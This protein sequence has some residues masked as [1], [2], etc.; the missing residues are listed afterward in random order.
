MIDMDT[1]H[2]VDKILDKIGQKDLLNILVNDLSY[3]ELNS[4]L[5]E[6]YRR[7]TD[8]ISPT[9]LLNSYN[10][11]RFVH[12]TNANLKGLLELE[13]D[14]YKIAELFSFIPIDLSPVEPLGACSVIAPVNQN[15]VLSALR[16]TE[17]VADATNSM[18]LHI[19]NLKKNMN[20][21]SDKFKEKMRYCN[22]HHHIRTQKF[23]EPGFRPHFRVFSMITSGKDLGSYTFE[24]N[25]ILEHIM[26]YKEIFKQLFDI[27]DL[28]LR[29]INSGGYASEGLC[30][31]LNNHIEENISDLKVYV[32]KSKLD[33]INQYY[34]GIQ[35]KLSTIINDNEYEIVDG[36]FV[37]WSQKLLSNRKERMLTSGFGVDFLLNILNDSI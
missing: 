16:G 22:M 15:K 14:F 29:L 5:M 3:S 11:N 21:Q 32:N 23:D 1:N 4:L 36:G 25:S 31:S 34:K 18:A 10:N 19:C 33:D 20:Q 27:S 35:F 2:L 13:I 8:K 6:V 28:K 12:P 9:E 26:I 17:V 30:N 24:K 7:K 37:D